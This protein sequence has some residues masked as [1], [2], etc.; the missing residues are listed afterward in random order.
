MRAVNSNGNIVDFN[1]ANVNDSFSYKTKITEQTD[2]NGR[3]DNV[4]IMILLKMLK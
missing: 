3:I 1:G 4:E 2:S